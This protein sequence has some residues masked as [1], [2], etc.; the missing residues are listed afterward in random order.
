LEEEV[1]VVGGEVAEEEVEVEIGFKFGGRLARAGCEAKFG[2]EDP[3]GVGMQTGAW[4]S[5]SGAAG[6]GGAEGGDR[7]MVFSSQ[8]RCSPRLLR[9]MEPNRNSRPR[10]GPRASD[11]WDSRG[12]LVEDKVRLGS[13]ARMKELVWLC[14]E[15]SMRKSGTRLARDALSGASG[16][17]CRRIG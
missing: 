3:A 2:V 10:L 8:P 1:E 5:E 7:L 12:F 13:S 15:Q 14:G 6:S 4:L 9:V 16:V 17:G 11:S